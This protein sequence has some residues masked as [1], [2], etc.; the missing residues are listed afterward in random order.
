MPT[1]YRTIPLAGKLSLKS[2]PSV[3]VFEMRPGLVAVTVHSET[4]HCIRSGDVTKNLSVTNLSVESAGAP[5]CDTDLVLESPECRVRNA[6][7]QTA[8]PLRLYDT[9]NS[10][11]HTSATPEFCP[12][13][14]LDILFRT[15][16]ADADDSMAIRDAIPLSN[17][18]DVS[19]W[20]VPGSDLVSLCKVPERNLVA[21]M[22]FW[23][24]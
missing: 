7:N 2:G 16:A 9:G 13:R 14:A 18:E 12:V 1:S 19:W 3:K 20:L 10:Q 8:P 23:S 6:H 15:P 22:T 17:D 5:F 4:R 11:P 21:V 24:R